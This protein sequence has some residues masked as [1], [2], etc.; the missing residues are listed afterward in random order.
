MTVTSVPLLD[1]AAQNRP[2]RDQ[3][4]AAA[5]RIIDDGRF[6]MGP[7]VAAFEA[8]IAAFASVRH[9]VGVSSGTDALLVSLMALGVHAGDEVVTTPFSFYA[10]VG[11]IVRLSARP[12]FADID[13]ET[14]NLDPAAAAAA[15]GARTRAVIPVHLFGRPAE[16][17]AVAVPIVEDAAQSIGADALRGLAAC[18]S[19]F[20]SKNLGGFGDA[21]AVATNDDELAD[22][23]RLLRTHGSRPKYVH[24]AVGG[25][26]RIDTLQA[27][28]L[29]VKLPHLDAWTAQRRVNARRYEGLFKETPGIPA[30]LRVPAGA[31]GHIYNQFVIRAPRR[32]ELRTHLASR[33]V[34]TEVYYPLPFHLQ[35][36]FQGLGYGR[37]AF[38]EAEKAAA[39]ALALPIFPEL[40]ADQQGYVVEEIAAFYRR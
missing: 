38:P 34:G 1:V 10:T 12:V 3:L 9:V 29:R 23:I 13:P 7:D 21:G 28:L 31:P 37:G 5:T 25:N 17:P 27:A 16:L 26:F 15:C 32:D 4:V 22:R 19:F 35:P 11:A 6:V 18:F 24:Q 8:E 39:E 30:D 2:L 33:G 36:C 20:P 14:F 40:T